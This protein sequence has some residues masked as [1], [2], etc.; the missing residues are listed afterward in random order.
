MSDT[1]P[2]ILEEDKT[3]SSTR[4]S[5]GAEGTGLGLSI[6]EKHGAYIEVDSV[7]GQGTT[8]RVAFRCLLSRLT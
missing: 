2:G 5:D 8:F 3:V 7:L 1:G 6:S 4:F